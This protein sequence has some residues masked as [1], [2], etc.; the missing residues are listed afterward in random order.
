[1]GSPPPAAAEYTIVEPLCAVF[2]RTLKRV[3]Q[4]YTPER[5]RILE[6]VLAM[7]ELFQI[8]D[9]MA[10]LNTVSP[11]GLPVPAAARVSKA[12]VYRT[13][14]LLVTAGIIQHA[15]LDADQTHYQLAYGRKPAG[16]LF[17]TSSGRATQVDIPELEGICRRVCGAAGV[18]PQGWRLVIYAAG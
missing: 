7:G 3:G 6:A 4:K 17:D 5:A 11:G 10:R 8:D 9:L 14:K 2:R 13:L 1:M 18:K 16:W 12:T 15:L